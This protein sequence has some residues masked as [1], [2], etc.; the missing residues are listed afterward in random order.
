MPECAI[1]IF[2]DIGS[3]FF[4]KRLPGRLGL[5]LGLTGARLQGAQTHS[6]KFR[7]LGQLSIH[8]LRG[9]KQP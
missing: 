7:G 4:L 2:P 5:W 9:Y 3:S 1:G 8:E 6:L